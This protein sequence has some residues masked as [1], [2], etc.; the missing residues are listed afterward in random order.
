MNHQSVLDQRRMS[1]CARHALLL[2]IAA[3]GK[4]PSPVHAVEVARPSARWGHGAAVM[5]EPALRLPTSPDGRDRIVTWLAL[6]EG[7]KIT[8]QR[9]LLPAGTVADRVE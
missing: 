3:C 4:S 2:A 8:T 1:A 6:P 7:G 9:L 5:L